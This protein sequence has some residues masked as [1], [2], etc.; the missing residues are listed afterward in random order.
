M[1]SLS[2]G[3]LQKAT[4]KAILYL[5]KDNSTLRNEFFGEESLAVILSRICGVEIDV[6]T[7][8]KAFA[9]GGETMYSLQLKDMNIGHDAEHVLFVYKAHRLANDDYFTAVGWFDSIDDAEATD[10]VIR[11]SVRTRVTDISLDKDALA[12]LKK[13]LEKDSAKK[14]KAKAKH[15]NKRPPPSTSLEEPQRTIQKTASGAVEPETSAAAPTPESSTNTPEPAATAATATP[16][17]NEC[18]V[19]FS[20]NGMQGKMTIKVGS[21]MHKILLENC[22]QDGR[23]EEVSI[24]EGGSGMFIPAVP[25]SAELDDEMEVDETDLDIPIQ[26]SENERKTY[27]IGCRDVT[28]GGATIH[29]V[30]NTHEVVQSNHLSMW[31]K[32]AEAKDRLVKLFMKGKKERGKTVLSPR[33]L[34]FLATVNL[35]NSGGS[36]KGTVT[37]LAAMALVLIRSMGISEEEIS[38]E[39]IAKGCPCESTIA[40]YEYHAATSLVAM[41]TRQINRSG[42]RTLSLTTDGGHRN[43]LDHMVKMVHYYREDDEGNPSVGHFTIDVDTCGKSADKIAKAIKRST[44]PI[45]TLLSDDIKIFSQTGDSGGGGAVQTI[46]PKLIDVGVL[47]EFAKFIKCVMHAL[48]KPFELSCTKAFGGQGL[49]K[50]TV[51]QLAFSV[52]TFY[53]KIIEQ[54]GLNL[55]DRYS[56]KFLEIFEGN[57]EWA[58]EGLKIFPQAMNMFEKKIDD[59]DYDTLKEFTQ[60]L[61]NLQLPVMTRWKTVPKALKFLVDNWVPTYF[62][63][64]AVTQLEGSKSALYQI[65]CDIL[66]LMT[67]RPEVGESEAATDA[68]TTEDN[69]SALD[70]NTEVAADAPAASPATAP[71]PAADAPVLQKGDT[72]I[73]LSQALFLV[74]F[75]EY[76]FTPWFDSAM[77]ADPEFGS[78][79]HGHKTRLFVQQSYLMTKE[80][81]EM[82]CDDKWKEL[83]VFG[84]FITSLDGLPSLGD[85]K[86]GGLEFINKAVNVF[87][88]EYKISF[89]KHITEH[90]TSRMIA[91]YIIGGDPRLAR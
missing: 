55:V 66:S 26:Q 41:K 47:D 13:Q 7:V 1:P 77:Q 3:L 35:Q 6:D 87:F 21:S 25:N 84:P 11:R 59:D 43:K 69:G 80:L 86:K 40:E 33:Y 85:V 76:H 52:I 57:E 75:S 19:T 68:D 20:M 65:C 63:C 2:T 71:A 72:L 39:S 14:A 50:S 79:S 12:E 15:T 60:S 29:N 61:R 38:N 54:G 18:T 62:M 46:F 82:M 53:R 22:V 58:Q 17:S 44:T 37:L 16:E 9:A 81:E 32:K 28:I 4:R 67:L 78:D 64:V 24:E 8:S 70:E 27:T 10:P 5:F 88:R 42:I 48:S 30:P 34:Q 51:F 74:G 90:W 91:C 56:D 73:L 49:G 36:D 89:F 45:L 83:S 31:K 23:E